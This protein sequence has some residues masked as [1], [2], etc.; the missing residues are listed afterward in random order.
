MGR[1]SFFFGER[2]PKKDP[3]DPNDHGWKPL[4][5]GRDE[6]KRLSDDTLLGKKSVVFFPGGGALGEGRANGCCKSAQGM[7]KLSGITEMPHLYGFGYLGKGHKYQRHEIATQLKQA[8][9]G[10]E[11]ILEKT[12]DP[13]YYQP[14]FEE[15]ILP[16]FIN[17]KGAYGAFFCPF[18]PSI[19]ALYPKKNAKKVS[20]INF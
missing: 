10:E 19:C 17:E 6:V 2:V 3:N 9:F 18:N 12:E 7:L 1:S 4:Y 20:Q 5:N 15:Y 13:P 11:Y 8:Q 14:F 16:L